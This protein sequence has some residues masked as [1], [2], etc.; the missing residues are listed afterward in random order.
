MD[1]CHIPILVIER[2]SFLIYQFYKNLSAIIFV[3]NSMKPTYLYLLTP[4]HKFTMFKHKIINKFVDSSCYLTKN[5]LITSP[6]LLSGKNH[7]IKIT[8]RLFINF[9]ILDSYYYYFLTQN[10]NRH[11]LILYRLLCQCGRVWRVSS[12]R[13][14]SKRY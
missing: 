2:K 12:E 1:S 9:T 11:Y 7:S 10:L 3:H 13:Q 4:L 14:Q 5:L 8:K 6:N